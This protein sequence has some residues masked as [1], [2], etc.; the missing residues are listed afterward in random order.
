MF[1]LGSIVNL[2]QYD[3]YSL[4]N[5]DLKSRGYALSSYFVFDG[6]HK[7][8]ERFKLVFGVSTKKEILAQTKFITKQ[9]ELGYCVKW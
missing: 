2:K 6:K 7:I 4:L 3:I 9:F 1:W 5:Y 8:F